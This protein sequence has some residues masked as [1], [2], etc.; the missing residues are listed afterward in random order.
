[1]IEGERKN[2]KW[3]RAKKM[4]ARI[5]GFLA[6]LK[7]YKHQDMP[8]DLIVR[9]TPIVKNEDFTFEIM[10]SKSQA[11]ANLLSWVVNVYACNRIYVTVKPLME[12]LEQANK[13][14]QA[15]E[16]KL[17]VVNKLVAQ[18][19]AQFQ[20]LENSFIQATNDK[21]RVEAQAKQCKE[22][23]DLANRL[24]FGLGSEKDRW[25]K[26]IE[27]LK[28]RESNLTGD[29]LLAAAFVSYVGGFDNSRRVK[30]WKSVWIEVSLENI[31]A[32]RH[33]SEFHGM[34]Y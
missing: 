13:D 6:R 9:L 15:A 22:R 2:F 10:K 16:Q 21:A 5:D 20:L 1:M 30:L 33:P 7:E 25:G 29:V 31:N 32:V 3:A 34:C 26:E 18:V 24:I 28:L 27:Q 23:L 12:K 11:A 19:E 17:Q 8:E 4:M 14:Q